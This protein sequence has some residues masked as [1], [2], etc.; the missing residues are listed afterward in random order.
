MAVQPNYRGY[1]PTTGD[2]IWTIKGE[3]QIASG[4]KIV[5]ESGGEIEVASGGLVTFLTDAKLYFRD[6]GLYIYSSVNGTLNIVSDSVVNIAG[7]VII[8]AGALYLGAG[9]TVTGLAAFN[10]GI[11]VAGG[12]NITGATICGGGLSV[13]GQTDLQIVYIHSELFAGGIL[14]VPDQMDATLLP[15]ADPAIAGRLWVNAGVVTRSAG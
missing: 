3:Q 6:T 4:G 14:H 13:A 9:M 8:P 15:A 12:I 5:V 10:S 2:D 7:I 1:N 11:G